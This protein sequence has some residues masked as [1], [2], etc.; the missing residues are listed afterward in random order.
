MVR[1]PNQ[2]VLPKDTQF[3]PG[4]QKRYHAHA[5]LKTQ[6]VARIVYTCTALTML[7]L[8]VYKTPTH[9]AEY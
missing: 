2:R 1:N 8:S 3:R 9:T 6:E 5:C 4:V 7:L